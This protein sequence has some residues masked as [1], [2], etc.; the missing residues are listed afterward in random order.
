MEKVAGG[1]APLPMTQSVPVS[2]RLYK[3]A[4]AALSPFAPA[5]LRRRVRLGKEDP[6]R[7]PERLGE[8][9]LVRPSGRLAWLHGVSVGES[10]SLLPLVAR[11][12]EARPDI[13][14]L[15]TSG[16]R[17][18][19]ELLEARLCGGALHQYA[20][21]DTPG[22]V[23]RFLDTW[24]PELGVFAESELWPNLILGAKARGAR[25][26]LISARLSESSAD[27]W[28][29]APMAVRALLGAFDL[30]LARDE[31]AARRFSS[32]GGRVA[33]LTDLKF[34][35]P[36]L[37]VDPAA[38]AA[39]ISAVDGRSVL[40]AAS[41]H[42]GEDTLILDA[43]REVYRNDNALLIIAP[44]HPARGEAIETL[45]RD[46][47]LSVSRRSAGAD[48]G[49]TAV[50]VADTV[51]ELGLWYRLASLAVVGGSLLPGVAGG[52]NPLEPARLG[53]PFIS[54]PHVGDWPV[55]DA[56]EDAA[57]TRLAPADHLTG[58]F[59]RAIAAPSTL[60]KMADRA[61][62]FA[63]AGDLAAGQTAD[64]ILELLAP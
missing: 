39:A 3:A 42:P 19:A 12:R 52:H 55:Y 54:G 6:R 7:W 32:L 15:V 41:T 40:L 36:V 43:F 25:L 34:G 37:P 10:L 56:L 50:Y 16:T 14:L 33:G 21:L 11:L 53:C 1:K 58:W 57:A 44:R 5:W 22:A 23:D 29:R 38:L 35:S 26:A 20:P 17:A 27:A 63:A 62:A 64:H 46:H 48:L 8:S 2:L 31:A 51:G 28:R 61:R 49:D 9:S 60:A 24:R 47:G 4:A 59:S 18:A 13:T 30:I 45:A